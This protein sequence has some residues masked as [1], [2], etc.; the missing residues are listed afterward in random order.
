MPIIFDFWEA[1]KFLKDGK[2]VA[3]VNWNGKGLFLNLQV[4]DE[5]SY[6]TRPYIYIT[7]PKGN[8]GYEEEISRIPRLASQTDLLWEDWILV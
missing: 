1:L 2:K 5:N 8:W 7:V 6:M 4:P 3:R